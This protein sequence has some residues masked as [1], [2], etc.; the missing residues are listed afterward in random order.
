MGD[1]G[2]PVAGVTSWAP[3]PLT[4]LWPLEFP[5]PLTLLNLSPSQWEQWD[6]DATGCV[7]EAARSSSRCKTPQDARVG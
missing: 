5:V 6:D 2:V 4:G 7:A 3:A 1:G